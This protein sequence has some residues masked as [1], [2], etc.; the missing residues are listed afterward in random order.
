MGA[1]ETVPFPVT[2]DPLDEPPIVEGDTLPHEHALTLQKGVLDT[3]RKVLG[4]GYFGV[5][6]HQPPDETLADV[7]A[8]LSEA[9]TKTIGHIIEP[10]L[11]DTDAFRA[12]NAIGVLLGDADV[13]QH[14]KSKLIEHRFLHDLK[15][16]DHTMRQRAL[17]FFKDHPHSV[18]KTITNME[19]AHAHSVI[20]LLTQQLEELPY[21]Y[22]VPSREH[23]PALLTLHIIRDLAWEPQ[24]YAPPAMINN[25]ENIFL[26][27]WH[28]P[29]ELQA[30]DEH[31]PLVAIN[32]E[33]ACRDALE[34]ILLR[35]AIQDDMPLNEWFG[36]IKRLAEEAK[37]DTA[38]Q[39]FERFIELLTFDI[40]HA[41]KKMIVPFDQHDPVSNT[42]KIHSIAVLQPFWDTHIHSKEIRPFLSER[43]LSLIGSYRKTR[44]PDSLLYTYKPVETGGQ[45]SQ[46]IPRPHR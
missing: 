12:Y 39:R 3:Y 28:V 35:Q 20:H 9:Q 22:D 16:E 38:K 33:F 45:D 27:K 30:N 26:G 36:T 18:W 7:P 8:A 19:D 29:N 43:T 14:V 40:Y 21:I 41:D 6:G 37:N 46:K 10:E 42:R 31:V 17:K 2:I 25:L 15:D 4:S 5:D 13:P 44:N 23:P 1:P 24:F 32:V 11:L 34:T